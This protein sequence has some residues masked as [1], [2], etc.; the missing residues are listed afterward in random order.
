M[1][2]NPIIQR[3]PFRVPTTDGKTIL[4]HFGKAS[5]GNHD[6]S[7]AHMFAPPGWNEPFQTPQ[8]DEY[9]LVIRGR[10]RIELPHA[11]VDVGAGESICVPAGT[12]VRYSNPFSDETEYVSICLPAFSPDS[13]HR[14]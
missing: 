11:T 6:V 2:K 12:R 8:F 3:E 13:V 14:E 1:N 4:E 5:S 10:K 7:I 9:T